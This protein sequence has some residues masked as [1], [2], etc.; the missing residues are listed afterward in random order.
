MSFIQRW[1][2]VPLALAVTA[3]LSAEPYTTSQSDAYMPSA[4][5]PVLGERSVALSANATKP[6]ETYYSVRRDLR[7]CMSP[8]CGGYWVRSVNHAR[9]ECPDGSRAEE[10]YVAEIVLP[11]EL[12][13]DSGD[14]VHGALGLR[15]YPELDVELGALRADFALAPVL[16]RA[17]GRGH[18]FL[19]HDTGIRCVTT[20]C[21]SSDV[22][23]LNRRS[24]Y[25]DYALSFG[26]AALEEP[27]WQE[28]AGHSAAGQG[29]VVFG[30]FRPRA[31]RRTS[32]PVRELTVDNVYVTKTH[33]GAV[34]LSARQEQ[35]VWA[36]NVASAEEAERIAAGLAT[37]RIENGRC[38]ALR[39]T[40][41]ALY[42]PVCGVVESA[43]GTVTSTFSNACQMT[44][45][46]V[47]AAG[48][49]S[50]ARGSY[51]Q[52]ACEAEPLVCANDADCDDSFCG[53]ATDGARICKPWA[54]LGEHCEGFVLP[55]RRSFCAPDL[56]CVLSEPTG[57]AGGTCQAL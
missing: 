16:A 19:V 54:Q 7:R 42:A 3:C 41:I 17:G 56:T 37:R 5:K 43:E 13:L 15:N 6:T 49:D 25:S 22:I 38:D 36:W 48:F 8:F 21:P 53:W 45:A 51:V 34:C 46:V 28:Y 23:P 29:A 31:D 26:D 44:A 52:G 14:L 11:P 32:R 18:H 33:K 12:T 40:C 50:K 10:C 57:D 4:G 35:S 47:A 2:S 24:A 1:M 30:R 20:P 39:T 27:Y 55:V 9:T